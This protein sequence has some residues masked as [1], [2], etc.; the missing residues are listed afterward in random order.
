MYSLLLP[1]HTQGQNQF[2]PKGYSEQQFGQIFPQ[3]QQQQIGTQ[4]QPI[5]QHIA[6]KKLGKITV[7]DELER[8]WKE[9]VLLKKSKELDGEEVLSKEVL[10]RRAHTQ[11]HANPTF[12][13]AGQMAAYE[14]GMSFVAMA[15]SDEDWKKLCAGELDD[16]T[17][18]E[19]FTKIE[20][21]TLLKACEIEGEMI[22]KAKARSGASI[23]SLGCRLDKCRVYKQK[24]DKTFDMD[25][26]VL[27]KTW[28]NSKLHSD[29]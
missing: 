12:K 6:F 28:G 18:T 11:L 26:Y 21:E 8:M 2:L 9:D 25:E 10:F 16:K 19:L 29:T 24:S 3:Q 15:I 14:K 20:K 13:A 4:P 17:S 23:R 5:L 1:F 27:Q 7:V 22:G